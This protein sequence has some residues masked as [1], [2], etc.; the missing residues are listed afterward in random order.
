VFEDCIKDLR[1]VISDINQTLC[2]DSSEE[3]VSLHKDFA[4][5]LEI[6]EGEHFALM[7]T[8]GD[9]IREKE[10]E[11]AE[12]NPLDHLVSVVLVRLVH[13]TQQVPYLIPDTQ[14]VHLIVR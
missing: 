13:P 2:N 3:I 8:I 6:L 12:K 4:D 10:L 5:R 9:F 14:N 11:V 1:F 7:K